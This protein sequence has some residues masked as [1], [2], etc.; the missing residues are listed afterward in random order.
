LAEGRRIAIPRY[1]WRRRR[2][3]VACHHHVRFGGTTYRVDELLKQVPA[4]RNV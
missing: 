2:S 3:A 1:L 4:R